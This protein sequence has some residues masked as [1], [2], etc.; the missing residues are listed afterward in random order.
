MK[1][2]I[3]FLM[4]LIS[5]FTYV[6]AEELSCNTTLSKGTR[7]T[8]VKTLQK[9]LNEQ[10]G[11]GLQVDGIYGNKTKACVSKFQTKNNLSETGTVNKS[12]C[13]LLNNQK[14]NIDNTTYSE[15]LKIGS[16]G[17]IVKE[18]QTKLN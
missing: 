18:M 15:T 3:I 6:E 4:V 7:G 14:Q 10:M 17:Q 5:S 1:K 12:T 9:I 13:S 2:I 11:C 16:R 8:N